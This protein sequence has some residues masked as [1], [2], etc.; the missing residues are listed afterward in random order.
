MALPFTGFRGQEIINKRHLH[1][2]GSS[3]HA[4]GRSPAQKAIS[5]ELGQGQGQQ[6]TQKMPTL[7]QTRVLLIE[8]EDPR[9][10]LFNQES[11]MHFL[12]LWE[13]AEGGD[14]AIKRALPRAERL[15]S[16]CSSDSESYVTQDKE[17][18]WQAQERRGHFCPTV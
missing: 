3:I 12:G 8:L 1:K 10:V 16:Y 14:P 15:V 7:F 4:A 18:V 13:A 6:P 9:L 2:R 5:G 17:D 11:E